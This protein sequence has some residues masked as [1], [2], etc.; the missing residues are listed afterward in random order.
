MRRL[1]VT[2]N[3][4]FT[5][6]EHIFGQCELHPEYATAIEQGIVREQGQASVRR[7][8]RARQVGACALG[9]TPQLLVRRYRRRH[10]VL[11]LDQHSIWHRTTS[12]SP[13][14]RTNEWSEPC[15]TAVWTHHMAML[16][17]PR[18]LACLWYGKTAPYH[19]SRLC[20]VLRRNG[21]PTDRPHIQGQ[22]IVL[23]R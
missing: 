22:E 11:V 2:G 13:H 17:G 15:A 3:Q 6:L 16:H 23:Y 5:S 14:S 1:W 21:F 20:Y 12:W 9:F 4:P 8:S 7:Q 18:C 19:D 10:A